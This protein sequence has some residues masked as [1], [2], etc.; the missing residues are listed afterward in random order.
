MRVPSW[1]AAATVLGGA[2]VGYLYFRLVGCRTGSCPITSRWWTSTGYGAVVGYFL[3]S[4]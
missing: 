3:A 1:R 4:R 2:L